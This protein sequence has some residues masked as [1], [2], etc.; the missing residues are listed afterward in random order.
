MNTV[1]NISEID[2]LQSIACSFAEL[3]D[4][5]SNHD[6]AIEFPNSAA[7]YSGSPDQVLRNLAETQRACQPS[8]R[9]QFVAF[10]GGR[11]VGLSVVGFAQ[12]VPDGIDH[13]WP[14]V[15]SFVCNPYR[16]Q[17]IGRLSLLE[18]LTAVDTQFNGRAWTAVKKAN[19]FSHRMVTHAGF[20]MQGED[21]DSKIYAYH[22]N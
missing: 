9:Q 21:G 17:G 6:I 1:R 15:S 8:V 13:S 4:D 16:N 3:L 14:N 5:P 7:R 19:D 22:S 12:E 2:D 20:V 10:S 11:A 18:Q